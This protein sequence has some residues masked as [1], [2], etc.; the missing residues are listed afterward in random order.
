MTSKCMPPSFQER[1]ELAKIVDFA[2]QG[3][4]VAAV[5]RQ[6]GLMPF[7]AQVLNRKSAMTQAYAGVGIGPDSL[8]VRTAMAE[9]GHHG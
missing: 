7:G 8:I 4:N 2:V 9:C 3:E 1:S 6:H 5:S